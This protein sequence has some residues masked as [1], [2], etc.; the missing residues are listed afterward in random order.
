MDIKDRASIVLYLT[1]CVKAVILRII[2][3]LVARVFVSAYI[4]IMCACGV[5]AARFLHSVPNK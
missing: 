4:V 1:L 2:M 5:C 3:E